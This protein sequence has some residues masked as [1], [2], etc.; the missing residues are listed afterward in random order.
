MI[1]ISINA[2]SGASATGSVRIANSSGF[3]VIGR[4]GGSTT[5]G[6]MITM[7]WQNQPAVTAISTAGANTLTIAQILTNI[8]TVTQTA[9]VTLTLPTGTLVDAGVQGGVL[10][11]RASMD[12]SVI[13]LGTSSGAVT[14]AA[15]TNH[16]YVGSTSVPIGTSAL[17]RTVKISTN[18]FTTYRV[19]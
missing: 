4:N 16:T 5:I 19:G 1:D 13:N 18:S 14:I 15:G 12:W 11:P 17:F 2:G 8:I 6:G 7:P 10:A 9:A 3:F